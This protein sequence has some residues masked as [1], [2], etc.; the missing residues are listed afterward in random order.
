MSYENVDIKQQASLKRAALN[1]T[2][3]Q[4]IFKQQFRLD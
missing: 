1:A 2:D 4:S 3:G